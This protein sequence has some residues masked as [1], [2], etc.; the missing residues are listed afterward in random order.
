MKNLKKIYG[1]WK[2]ELF[3]IILTSIHFGIRPE[4]KP[5]KLISK[6][7]QTQMAPAGFR[8]AAGALTATLVVKNRDYLRS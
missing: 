5:A 1:V 3:I 2:I 6:F 4:M 7:S 8:L